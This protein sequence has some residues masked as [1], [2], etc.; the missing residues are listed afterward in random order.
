MMICPQRML[1]EDVYLLTSQTINGTAGTYSVPSN[2]KFTNFSGTVYTYTIT[3]MP[4]GGFSFRIGVNGWS[5]NMQPYS[6]D[7]ALNINGSSYTISENCYGTDK[8]WKVSY[9][10]GTYSS[11]TITVDLSTSNRYVKITGTTA[12]SGSNTS[13]SGDE[14]AD[15][16]TTE[17][18][19]DGYGMPADF[20]GI[21]LRYNSTTT[22]TAG[23]LYD[24]KQYFDVAY[25]TPDSK[26]M[27]STFAPYFSYLIKDVASHSEVADGWDGYVVSMTNSTHPLSLSAYGTPK[28]LIGNWKTSNSWTVGS[29]QNYTTD[30][31]KKVKSSYAGMLDFPLRTFMYNIEQGKYANAS[32]AGWQALTYFSQI[33]ANNTNRSS[34]VGKGSETTTDDEYLYN[35]L[36]V[37]FVNNDKIYDITGDENIRKAYAVI[38]TAPGTPVVNYSDLSN[39]NLSENILR[40]AQIR[41]WAGVTNTSVFTSSEDK[42]YNYA[43]D[44]HV[45]GKF[46]E[47][48][49]VVGDESYV[50]NYEKNGNNNETSGGT[51]DRN[52][53]KFGGDGY[54]YTLLAEGT[55]WRVWYNNGGKANA[56][57]VAL[58]PESG[59][60]TGTV[61]CTGQVIGIKGSGERK[62]AYTTNGTAPTLNDDGTAGTGST[63]VTYTWNSTTE[64]GKVDDFSA[65]SDVVVNNGGYV[66]VIAQA[67]QNGALVGACDTVTYRFTDYT[68]LSIKINP[69]NTTLNYGT[70]IAPIITV[71][72]PNNPTSGEKYLVYSLTNTLDLRP[73][74]FTDPTSTI[75]FKQLDGTTTADATGYFGSYTADGVVDGY[76]PGTLTY[77]AENDEILLND[78]PIDQTATDNDGNKWT[79]LYAWAIRKTTDKDNNTIYKVEGSAVVTYTFLSPTSSDLSY[80]VI[81]QND[82]IKEENVTPVTANRATFTVKAW[83]TTAGGSY[84]A[85]N[86]DTTVPIYYTTD[87]SD[88]TTSFTR[89]L[90]RDR[91]ITVYA[92]NGTAMSGTVKVAITGATS[93]TT[94]AKM[95][96]KQRRVTENPTTY[97]PN[98]YSEID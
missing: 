69:G 38:L 36:G 1:A 95:R 54:N 66:T 79:Y 98:D 16:S 76:M 33:A 11:L 74:S 89:R 94:P 44:Y 34:I 91:K 93:S 62:F 50:A 64:S 70:S 27:K 90:V 35:R 32:A 46:A 61:N 81:V 23:T 72:D 57:H 19:T 52:N 97:T 84:N 25:L 49:V 41:K 22:P 21:I 8:A 24:L 4:S 75:S 5:N 15:N 56:I 39:S 82:S 37:T 43:Y 3:S 58:S 48:K 51:E 13:T 42:N 40:L 17:S 6:N 78:E 83:S 10:D 30:Y 53:A 18:T 9:T 65:S 86:L 92:G 7:D 85:D 31:L 29:E 59:Y 20:G 14:S 63:I 47:L 28:F 55:G 12:S 73:E 88:P 67:I 68:P 96:A 71:V 45:K 26:S 2:H 80:K 77:D 60:K 87:G